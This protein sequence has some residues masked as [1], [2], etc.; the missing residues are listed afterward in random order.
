MLLELAEHAHAG[1]HLRDAG[2]RLA[3][4]LDRSE[5]FAVLELD[6]VHRHIDLRQVDLLVL[7][8]GKI[9]VIRLVSTVVADVAE[10]RAY[11]PL[12]V[13]GQRQGQIEPDGTFKRMPMS[14][15]IFSSG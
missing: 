15:A 13:E 12:I 9:V 8:V 7:A 3:L 10:E 1:Q 14:I 2:I 11:W 6:T 4:F 5:E